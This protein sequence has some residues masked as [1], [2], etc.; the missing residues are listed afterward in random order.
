MSGVIHSSAKIYIDG[1]YSGTTPETIKSIVPGNHKVE[2]KK[3]GYKVWSKRVKVKAGEEAS[4]FARL[5]Y[6]VPEVKSEVKTD[7][8]ESDS[9]WS[10]LP[11]G[12]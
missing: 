11:E 8:T 2:I 5:K 12:W 1:S 10:M 3:D 7:V 9:E 6:S 4:I